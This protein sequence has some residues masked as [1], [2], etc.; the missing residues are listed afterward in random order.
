MDDSRPP[1]SAAD[2]A[3]GQIAA[4]VTAAEQAAADIAANAEREARELERESERRA[5][6]VRKKAIE[7][8]DQLKTEAQAEA[9]R[10]AEIA[11]KEADERIEHAQKAADDVLA[12]AEALSIGLHQLATS[13][14]DQAETILR[15]VMAGHRRLLADLR[16][17]GCGEAPASP[18][19]PR[20]ERRAGSPLEDLEI[21][22]WA[23]K[24]S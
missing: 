10:I 19:P 2:I 23:E 13:L 8:G 17:G 6:E 24:E 4:I 16:V 14:E 21:P 3:A 15:D 22:T 11:R 1:I 7:E 5:S 18:A 12:Q 9:V 20:P